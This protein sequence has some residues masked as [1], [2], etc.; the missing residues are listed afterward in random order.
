M[1]DLQGFGDQIISGAITTIQVALASLAMG[2]VVG[3]FG[4]T[5]KLATSRALNRMADAYRRLFVACP[6][7]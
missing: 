7:F 5:A 1:I 3:L 2:T 4:A 6:S